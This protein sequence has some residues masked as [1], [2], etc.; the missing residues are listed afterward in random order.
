MWDR[1]GMEML[2]AINRTRNVL[3][4]PGEGI[5]PYRTQESIAGLLPG[6]TVD[7][8]EIDADYSDFEDF[9]TALLGGVGPA[10]VWAASLDGEQRQTARA[11][12]LHQLG[13][14]EGPF[15]MTGRAWAARLTRA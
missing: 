2:A 7:L 1:D 6:A 5:G 8:L 4:D 14:P 11:E 10:G 15:T 12:L 3:G 13:E 9:W